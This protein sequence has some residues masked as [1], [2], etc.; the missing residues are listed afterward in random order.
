MDLLNIFPRGIFQA[1]I[2]SKQ[3]QPARLRRRKLLL[4]SFT[5]FVRIIF[6]YSEPIGEKNI[7]LQIIG[8]YVTYKHCGHVVFISIIYLLFCTV[9]VFTFS[10]R[11]ILRYQPHTEDL[12]TDFA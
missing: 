2:L 3:W 4:Q 11:L 6:L 12:K 10:L 8:R 5:R 7:I 1:H 9:L